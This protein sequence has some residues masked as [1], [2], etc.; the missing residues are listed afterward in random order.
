MFGFGRKKSE[1]ASLSLQ[2][3][4]VHINVAP[5]SRQQCR[6]H[7]ARLLS[8]MNHIAKP[9]LPAHITDAAIEEM[10]QRRRHLAAA[11]ID[12]PQDRAGIERLLADMKE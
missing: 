12:A 7:L 1:V 11:G 8:L 9:H 10:R 5:A 6:R 4:P 2:G 3:Q